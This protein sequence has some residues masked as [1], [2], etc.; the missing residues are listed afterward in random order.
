MESR[1]SFLSD[2]LEIE[3]LM[4][5]K[6]AQKGIVITH[7]HPVYGGDMYNPVVDTI[8][9]VYRKKGYTTLRF[10]FRGT[11]QSQGKYDDGQGEQADV[12]AA[13][14]K[15]KADGLEEIHLAGY[16]FGAWVNARAVFSGLEIHRMVMVSPPAAMIDL[17]DVGSLDS[18]G[19][20]VTG[21]RDDIAPVEE[22]EKMMETWNKT[23]HLEVIGPAD[24]FYGGYLNDLAGV[25]SSPE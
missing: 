12:R 6:S 3:A 10:N 7:P 14:D 2:N 11:G 1:L 9:K 24:H 17:S 18:L 5:F 19:L 25:L 20:V 16:S 15:L 21:G 22:I 13:V 8:R 23:A 4:E